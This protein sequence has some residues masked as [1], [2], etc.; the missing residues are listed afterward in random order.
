MAAKRVK[1]VI[2][3]GCVVYHDGVAL[4]H[5]QEADV[6]AAEADLLVEQGVAKRVLVVEHKPAPAAKPRRRRPKPKA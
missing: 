5:G 1:V 3:P 6:S 4:G 2:E